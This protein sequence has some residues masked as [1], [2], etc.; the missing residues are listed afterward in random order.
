M[1]KTSSINSTNGY[2][3]EFEC[4][5]SVLLYLKDEHDADQ[6]FCFQPKLFCCKNVMKKVEL[7]VEETKQRVKMSQMCDDEV[8]PMDSVSMVSSKTIASIKLGSR[9]TS[10]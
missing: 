3:E 10:V 4:N 2:C 5:A 9:A 8:S 7:W 6:N 1:L